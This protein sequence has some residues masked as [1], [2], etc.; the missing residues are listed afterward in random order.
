MSAGF[1]VQGSGFRVQGM[2]FRVWGLGL[3]GRG[4]DQGCNVHVQ[5]VSVSW[6]AGHGRCTQFVPLSARLRGCPVALVS[7]MVMSTCECRA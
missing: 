1:E 7:S 6:V 4:Y 3:G 2:G 5:D